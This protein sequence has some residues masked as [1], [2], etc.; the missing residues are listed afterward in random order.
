MG[1]FQIRNTVNGKIFIDSSLDITSRQ[2]RHRAELKFGNHR[3]KGLQK[4]WQT[5]GA[6]NFVFETLAT[7]DYKDEG[8]TNYS[9]DLEDLLL[10]VV[11]DINPAEEIKYDS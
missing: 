7:L 5:F 11:E 3:N 6:A 1:V 10:I 2:N 8:Y 9:R 4:E